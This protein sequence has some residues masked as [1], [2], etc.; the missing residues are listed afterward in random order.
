M[1]HVLD[2]LTVAIACGKPVAR[3]SPAPPAPIVARTGCGTYQIGSD[4]R[5][6]VRPSGQAPAWAPHAVSHPAPGVWVAHPHGLLAVYRDGRLLW[7][8]RIRVPSDEVV[9]HGS[10]IAFGLY[11][12]SQRPTLWMARV[13]GHEFRVAEAEDPIGWTA[14]GLV[15]LHGARIRARG[16]DGT[17][18]RTLALGHGP[19]YD[20]G[21]RTVVFVRRDGAVLRT[22]GRHLWVLRRGFSRGAWL[23][24]LA[25]RVIQVMEPRRT[26]YL[27]PNGRRFWIGPPYAENVTGI[28]DGSVAL[29][30][31]EGLKGS[32]PGINVVELLSA[33]GRVRRLYSRAVPR[34]SCGEGASVSYSHGRL[35]YTDSEGPI[36]ILDPTGDRPPLELTRALRALQP[37]EPRRAQL[38]ADW[39][40]NWG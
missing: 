39:L 33:G 19:A 15:T 40:A 8:S 6:R 2:V 13:G 20:T 37:R 9:V 21:D 32:N 7:R 14:G 17:L 12:A 23:T 35:L 34:L 22:D 5:V 36:A 31:R 4:G 11:A 38:Y 29:I 30:T 10:S 24:V 1:K 27:H 26:V 28:P 3:V 25:N 16:P 18:Y